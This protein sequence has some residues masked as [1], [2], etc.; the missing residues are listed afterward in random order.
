MAAAR[1]VDYGK[2]PSRKVHLVTH[3]QAV[4]IALECIAAERKRLA[5]AAN[6]YA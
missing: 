2:S 4:R 3:A 5:V 6:L 1:V